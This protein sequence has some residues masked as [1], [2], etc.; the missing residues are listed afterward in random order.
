MLVCAESGDGAI[1]VALEFCFIAMAD[2]DKV[3]LD[4]GILD[5]RND[6]GGDCSWWGI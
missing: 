1:G 6:S 4:V 5:W 2:G 3:G